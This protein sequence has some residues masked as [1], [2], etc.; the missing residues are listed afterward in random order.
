METADNGASSLY[1]EQQPSG[2]VDRGI[3]WP[4]FRWTMRWKAI[5][6]I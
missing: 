2:S 5:S 6:H 1:Y 4:A 3:A